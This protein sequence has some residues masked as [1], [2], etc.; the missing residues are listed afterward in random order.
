LTY[1]GA[2]P[3]LLADH[4]EQ[5]FVVGDQD[6]TALVFDQC[7]SWSGKTII[8][9]GEFQ[10]CTRPSILTKINATRSYLLFI[11]ILSSVTDLD[12]RS[13]AF[14]TPGSGIRD[15]KK[16]IPAEPDPDPDSLQV[17]PSNKMFS[18]NIFA[19]L[20]TGSTF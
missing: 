1:L 13:G 4:F 8:N 14:F 5:S 18:N 10:K 7:M 11:A 12:L 15:G 17:L 16:F 2:N 3:E 19:L 20:F 6:H 9:E